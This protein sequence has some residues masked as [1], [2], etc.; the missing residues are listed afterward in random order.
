[1]SLNNLLFIRSTNRNQKK[2]GG[3]EQ[4]DNLIQETL[5]QIFNKNFHE[6]NLNKKNYTN[7]FSSFFQGHIDG[8][9]N[10]SINNILKI[11]YKKK[12]NIVFISGSN[13][14][15]LAKIIKFNYPDKKIIT[16]FHNIEVLFF[17]DLFRVNWK[18]KSFFVMLAN[19]MSERKSVLNS[20]VT[21]SISKEDSQ[22]LKKIYGKKSNFILPLSIKDFFVRYK[23]SNKNNKNHTLLFVGGNFYANVHG[24]EW[25]IQN[26]LPKISFKLIVIG[27]NLND[28]KKKYKLKNLQ[29]FSNVKNL[30]KWYKKSKFVISPIFYG[31]GMKTKVAEALMHGKLVIGTSKSFI[32]YEKKIKDICKISN[33]TDHFIKDLKKLEKKEFKFVDKKIRQIYLER[34]S[35]LSF[36]NK[37]IKIINSIS[38]Q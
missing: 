7:I 35:H 29:I 25:F 18:I 5:I 4:L 24:I 30:G 22:N 20:N 21:I 1:M 19:F 16:F 3:R 14:G 8:I 26:V 38:L 36:K 15:Q 12:I 33:S 9:D 6:I 34:Y 11:I 27:H 37:L 17:L 23:N 10:D 13:L 2:L 32:G 31:S 28:L